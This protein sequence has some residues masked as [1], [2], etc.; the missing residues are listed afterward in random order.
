MLAGCAS[1]GRLARVTPAARQPV[2]QS[3]IERQ[4]R[5]AVDAG[6][7]DFEARALRAHLEADP[8]SLSAR[9]ELAQHYKKK[10]FPE[11]AIEHL[12]L[13]V[14]RAPESAETAV[15]LAKMLRDTGRPAE[16]AAVL[17]GFAGMH[18]ASVDVWAWLGLLRDEAGDWKGG[19]EAHRKAIAL[20]PRHDDLHN[21]LGYCLLRQGRKVEAAEEFRTALQLNGRSVVARNNLGT[22]LT[23]SPLEAISHLQSVTDPASAHNNIAVALLEA[24]KYAEARQ[25]M[26]IALGYN[27]QNTAALNN[28]R[29]LSELDGKPTEIK[30][31]KAEADFA[32]S[33]Q[34][35]WARLHGA[36]LRVTGRHGIEKKNSGSNVASR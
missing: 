2:H 10:G 33:R 20:A 4:I 13:A 7:G 11:V 36:W 34:G 14:E 31:V 8:S 6:E 19:E 24:G 26:E 25:Q 15:S 32:K 29:L 5:N 22:T 1:H 30:A 27:R 9:T 3:A 28:L 23:D 35:R 17:S 18:L 12:R 21:N 16:G